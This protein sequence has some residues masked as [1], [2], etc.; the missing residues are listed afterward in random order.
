MFFYCSKLQNVTFPDGSLTNVYTAS[1]TFQNCTSLSSITFPDGALTQVE[2][3]IDCFKNCSRLQTLNILTLPEI[4]LYRIEFSYCISLTPESLMSIIEAL[5]NTTKD[6]TC[7][8]GT[9]NLSKLFSDQILIATN[10]GWK[11]N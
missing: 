3:P 2:F 9:T 11:L 4:N 10:K 8:I 1:G 7:T 6:Y 5:P